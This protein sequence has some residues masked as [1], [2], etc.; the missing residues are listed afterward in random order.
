MW[1][2]CTCDYVRHSKEKKQIN[3]R[4]SPSALMIIW[5]AG[6]AYC[7]EVPDL[8]DGCASALCLQRL[9]CL[10]LSSSLNSLQGRWSNHL[11]E[12][13]V[14][15]FLLISQWTLRATLP[16]WFFYSLCTSFLLLETI[17][18]THYHY[19]HQ[20]HFYININK[21]YV[22]GNDDNNDGNNWYYQ[23]YNLR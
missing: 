9:L 23:L 18:L 19:P 10:R 8:L 4:C 12:N 21:N 1:L 14:L 20:R 7:Q 5:F 15:C 22:N 2:L 6:L 11:S 3:Y 13:S 16:M 17:S